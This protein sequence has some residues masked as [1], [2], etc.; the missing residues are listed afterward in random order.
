MNC[1]LLGS[2]TKESQGA[3]HGG[4]TCLYSGPTRFW[5]TLT[6][7]FVFKNGKWYLYLQVDNNIQQHNKGESA[8][9]EINDHIYMRRKCLNYYQFYNKKFTT[10]HDNEGYWCYFNHI[11]KKCVNYSFMI[12]DISVCTVYVLKFIV[13]L[14]SLN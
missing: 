9:F 11:L 7:P 14:V 10:W 4:K 5:S 3:K 12:S 6:M 1:S 2:P 13:F 8:I